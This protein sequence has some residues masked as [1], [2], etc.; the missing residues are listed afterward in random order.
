MARLGT[1]KTYY[2][3]TDT[4][5]PDPD[6]DWRWA[7]TLDYTQDVSANTTTVTV[8]SNIEF[9]NQPEGA[10]GISWLYQN[11]INGIMKGYTWNRTDWGMEFNPDPIYYA[12]PAGNSTKYI[13]TQTF[14][15]NHNDDGTAKCAFSAKGGFWDHAPGYNYIDVMECSRTWTLPTINR[16]S[17]IVNNT[18]DSSR[19]DFG[20]P[21][22]FTADAPSSNIMNTLSYSVG[23]TTYDIGTITGDDTL[24]YIF[25]ANLVSSYPGNAEVDINVTCVS[26]NGT[27]SST[28][29][30]L[31]VP[32]SYVP[33]ISLA[34]TDIGTVPSN[35]GI[36][37]KGKSKL[38]GV[39]TAAGAGGSAISSYAATANKQSFSATPF[40]TTELN[41]VG[42]NVIT[43][44]VTDSRGRTAST[45]QTKT[46]YDYSSPTYV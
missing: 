16:Q 32:D 21:I 12:P 28:T 7:F 40:E 45:S 36:Y 30:Y 27:T 22:I 35:W 29:V 17:T 41:L 46:V 18:T 15:I 20:A 4:S 11:Y 37:V 25:P 24:Q 34:L 9:K 43:A 8:T 38:R 2:Y 26:S 6:G 42:S 14:T 33:T 31:K 39:I 19:I 13:A 1:W 23:G 5:I 3:M 44:S 10:L